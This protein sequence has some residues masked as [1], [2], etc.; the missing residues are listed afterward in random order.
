MSLQGEVTSSLEFQIYHFCS[1]VVCCCE[2]LIEHQQIVCPAMFIHV[3]TRMHTYA[4]RMRFWCLLILSCGVSTWD[5]VGRHGACSSAFG[6]RQFRQR[7]GVES[8]ALGYVDIDIRSAASCNTLPFSSIFE[9][10]YRLT[11]WVFCEECWRRVIVTLRLKYISSV[12]PFSVIHMSDRSSAKVPELAVL[13]HFPPIDAAVAAFF[14]SELLGAADLVHP[15]QILSISHMRTLV[16]KRC[17]PGQHRQQWLKEKAPCL[18][19]FKA[20]IEKPMKGTCIA[21]FQWV[22]EYFSGVNYA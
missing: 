21:Q 1:L 3:H 11:F 5:T 9:G 8:Q 2:V 18:R 12:W 20:L 4:S 6:Q 15:C 10:F 13:K 14:G 22:V 7:V 16:R 19:M 17:A